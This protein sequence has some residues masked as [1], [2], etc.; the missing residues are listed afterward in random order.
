[1]STLGD[2]MTK[3]VVMAQALSPM[4]YVQELMVRHRVSR[5]VIVDPNSVP[6]GIITDKDLLRYTITVNSKELGDVTAH[7]AMSKPLIKELETTPLSQCAR[8]MLDARIS[9]VVVVAR[10]DTIVGI[11]TKTDLCMFYAVNGG[12]SEL[13][14]ERMTGKPVTAR[15][16]QA[17]LDA[18]R[19]MVENRI[20]RIPVV[21]DHVEGIITLSDLTAAN[22]DIRRAVLLA[23]WK[24]EFPKG[25]IVASSDVDQIKIGDVMARN[26]ITV[27]DKDYLSD[28]AKSM[29]SH[30]IS[31]LPVLNAN[32]ALVG[33]VTKTDVAKAVASM[34]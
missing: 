1:M 11:V 21:N 26:P 12:R 8:R 6:L 20:S 14:Q 32:H 31:G 2:V 9:S 13:V 34:R 3:N 29:I 4:D 33:I 27:L 24:G 18:A 16:S 30:R 22:L 23:R 28:A 7:E 5:V 17:I 10:G 15:A 19:T 25:R